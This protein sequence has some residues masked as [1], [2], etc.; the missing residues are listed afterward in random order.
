VLYANA[1]NEDAAKQQQQ[2]EAA[3]S[4]GASAIVIQAVDGKA[5]KVI[6]DQA[7]AKG[8]PLI[9]YERQIQDS[10]NVKAHVTFDGFR[11][12]ELQGETLLKGMADRGKPKGP[13]VMINGSPTDSGA[14]IYSNGAKSKFKAADAKIVAEFDTPAWDPAK[15]QAQMDQWI[16][17]FGKD[18]FVGVYAANGGTAGGAIAAMKAGG[19]DL[20]QHPTTGQDADLVEIQRIVA[21]E[22]YM[23]V[24]K[25]IRKM[26]DTA[27]QM[28][29]ALAKGEDLPASLPNAKTDMGS[30]K[31][32]PTAKIDVVAVT[33]DTINDTVVKDGFYT[34]E[35][36]CTEKYAAACSSAGL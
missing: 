25:P 28:A 3:L 8:V 16:T 26:A 9:A 13:L 15:A 5:A 12:G 2:A 24:Y 4:N 32:I 18:G 23:T 10:D 35:E 27:A 31:Q 7:A 20:K 11:V 36:I 17:K 33:K 1:Q 29:I 34:V 6:A 22:Q 21:D 14:A 30:A 19:L